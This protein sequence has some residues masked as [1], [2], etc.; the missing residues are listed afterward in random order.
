VAS[1][2]D[3]VWVSTDWGIAAIDALSNEWQLWYFR[4]LEEEGSTRYVLARDTPA[5]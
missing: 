5:R 1:D 4:P 2:G 3:E